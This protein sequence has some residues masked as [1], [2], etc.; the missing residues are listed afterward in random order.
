MTPEDKT[1]YT[2]YYEEAFLMDVE[3]EYCANIEVCWST[4]MKTY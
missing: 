4:N 3:N 1:F 2:R